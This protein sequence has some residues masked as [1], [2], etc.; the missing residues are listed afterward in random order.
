[1][2]CFSFHSAALFSWGHAVVAN[3]TGVGSETFIPFVVLQ[4]TLLFSIRH[5]QRRT[6][7]TAWPTLTGSGGVRSKSTLVDVTL[8]VVSGLPVATLFSTT[9]RSVVGFV[10]RALPHVEVARTV[11]D[12]VST[13]R[14][15]LGT[16]VALIATDF[17]VFVAHVLMH[18]FAL[19]WAFHSVHHQAPTMTPLTAFRAHPIET[20]FVTL[21]SSVI[22][23]AIVGMWLT[24]VDPSLSITRILGANVIYVVFRAAFASLRHSAIPMSFGPFER[25]LVSPRMHQLHHSI[26]PMDHN[27][28]FGVVLSTWDRLWGTWAVAAASQPIAFGVVGKS[29]QSLN[30]AIIEPF[31]EAYRFITVRK[32]FPEG[33]AKDAI[34]QCQ[35]ACGCANV[36][37]GSPKG[38]C[39]VA[40]AGPPGER[41]RLETRT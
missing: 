7:R 24:L 31:V 41:T 6:G 33:T 16:L 21:V 34:Q 3:F 14:W 12:R 13:V 32:P 18:R 38:N 11:F 17:G 25:V 4:A 39:V 28:N 26:D 15:I 10:R 30:A 5:W 36:L 19:L 40:L 2:L 27:Q 20:F 22:G 8:L 23:G 37:A 1:M 35:P 9:N 29:G